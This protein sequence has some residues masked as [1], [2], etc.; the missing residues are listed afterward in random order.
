MGWL[1]A[2]SLL[3]FVGMAIG[4]ARERKVRKR[5]REAQLVA[6]TLLGEHGPEISEAL[7]RAGGHDLLDDLEMLRS[8][9]QRLEQ[10]IAH[11]EFKLQTIVRGIVEA[12]MVVD[13]QRVIQLV[14]PQLLTLFEL[15]QPPVNRTILEAFRDAELEL[16]ARNVIETGEPQRAELP[17]R[18]VF[19]ANSVRSF[20]VNG[21]ARRD[22]QG[23]VDGAVLTFRDVSRLKQLEQVRRDFVANVSHEL[24]TPLAIFRGYLET[25]L[26]HPKQPVKEL[27]RILQV[28]E[29]H[30]TRLNLL[31]EDLLSLARL[32]SPRSRMDLQ[33]LELRPFL[34]R[35]LDDWRLKLQP[36]QLQVSLRVEPDE[37][38][39]PA[40]ESRLEEVLHNLL[41]NAVKYSSDGGTIAVAAE[42]HDGAAILTVSDQGKGIPAADLPHVFER[43]YRVQ[44]ARTRD[45][46]GTG[47]GL[48]IVK[49]IVQLHGG[50]VSAESQ[51]GSGTT[52]RVRL[53]V[54][55]C[56]DDA[57]VVEFT[58]LGANNSMSARTVTRL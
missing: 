36:K 31:V 37:L 50:D 8:K 35:L 53:P 49:H 38:C 9:T 14:N 44:K 20:D 55:P 6:A 5:F 28:M 23:R 22:E 7:Y 21:T 27:V 16:L 15:K 25:L 13:A 11:E 32:E 29:K 26:D 47:L 34:E 48:S 45:E 2:L 24:R 58:R 39:V 42:Q 10:R 17:L 12:L 43:F 46:G 41:D 18:A 30:S 57:A 1:A 40:D 3:L 56:P 4:W 33:T 52:I 51:L 19:E 54:A